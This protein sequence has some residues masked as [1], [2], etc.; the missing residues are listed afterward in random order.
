M[1]SPSDRNTLIHQTSAQSK[2]LD[3]L[4]TDDLKLIEQLAMNNLKGVTTKAAQSLLDRVSTLTSDSPSSHSVNKRLL[5]RVSQA[6]DKAVAGLLSP[7]SAASSVGIS[8]AASRRSPIKPFIT[9]VISPKE[10]ITF[11]QDLTGKEAHLGKLN[12][13]ELK[14]VQNIIDNKLDKLTGKNLSDL[15]TKASPSNSPAASEKT[16]LLLKAP[17][18]SLLSSVKAALDKAYTKSLSTH[19]PV[20][21]SRETPST[22]PLK[23]SNFLSSFFSAIA[24]LI[25]NILS[26][27]FGNASANRPISSLLQDLKNI[28]GANSPILDD[29]DP[30]APADFLPFITPL[31]I[32]NSPP[33]DREPGN[34]S[35][36]INLSNTC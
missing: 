16:P 29:F 19:I 27:L 28:Y 13:N 20:K 23:N 34:K 36:L 7:S 5:T 11:I 6:L 8:A 10:R 25:Y 1:I 21:Q 3:K 26:A 15:L 35:G 22:P 9:T 14:T 32:N 18:S 17:S 4:N 24:H 30:Q 12:E 31:I 33:I 2:H